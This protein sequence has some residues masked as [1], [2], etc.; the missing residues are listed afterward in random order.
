LLSQQ[1]II[2]LFE[3]APEYLITPQIVDKTPY[4]EVLKFLDDRKR[5]SDA[6]PYINE[7][8]RT[9]L[10]LRD[11]DNVSEAKVTYARRK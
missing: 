10:V 8:T 1:E 2:T 3:N 4:K 7:T 5:L 9:F 11:T 6:I